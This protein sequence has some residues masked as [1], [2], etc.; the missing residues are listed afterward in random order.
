VVRGSLE[1]C[2]GILLRQNPRKGRLVVS[3]DI[4]QRS[5]SVELNVEDVEPV[6]TI[7]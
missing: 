7:G 3:I 4:I 2:V 5:V 1:G 6:T